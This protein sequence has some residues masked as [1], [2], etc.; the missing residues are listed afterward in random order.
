VKRNEPQR[1]RGHR[2]KKHREERKR[3]FLL[4]VSS[5]CVLCASVVRSA[6]AAPPAVTS[7][8]PAG[9]QRGTTVEVTAA[10]TFERWPVQA[11]ISGHGVAVAPGKDKG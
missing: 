7:L 4:C 10:G 2:G 11:W 1:H 9:A 8:F 3:F 5:L 6:C